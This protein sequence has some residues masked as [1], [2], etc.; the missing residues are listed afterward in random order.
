MGKGKGAPEY[1]VA[2]GGGVPVQIAENVIERR[3]TAIV[4]PPNARNNPS[5]FRVATSP[6]QFQPDVLTQNGK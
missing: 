6:E 5:D 3:A 2:V 1:W 4:F